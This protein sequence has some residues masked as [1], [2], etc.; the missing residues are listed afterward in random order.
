[1]HMLQSETHTRCPH[2]SNV[3]SIYIIL[4]RICVE[5]IN[6]ESEP[7]QKENIHKTKHV[8]VYTPQ[9]LESFQLHPIKSSGLLNPPFLFMYCLKGRK[10]MTSLLPLQ[11]CTLHHH[12]P[13]RE[14]MSASKHLLW[15]LVQQEQAMISV[16]YSSGLSIANETLLTN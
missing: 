15:W 4:C 8:K 7:Q 1:M 13:M 2:G 5:P 6:E 11:H 10:N 12:P 16:H 14:A 3:F 9:D